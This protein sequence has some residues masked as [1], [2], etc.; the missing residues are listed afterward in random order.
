M[1]RLL[2]M[3]C[4]LL[5]VDR[6]GTY[7]NIWRCRAAQSSAERVDKPLNQES[8]LLRGYLLCTLPPYPHLLGSW[9]YILLEDIVICARV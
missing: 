3:K 4:F 7:M 5:F 8:A 9:D 6:A 2:V 1:A